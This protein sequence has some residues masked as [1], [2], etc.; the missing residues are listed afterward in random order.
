[1]RGDINQAALCMTRVNAALAGVDVAAVESDLLSGVP[2]DFDL[3]VSNP[4]YL[5][6]PGARAYRHG[7]GDLGAGIVTR[8]P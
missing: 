6:D 2:G 8:Y 4:P 5:V 1:M 3:I 7:G